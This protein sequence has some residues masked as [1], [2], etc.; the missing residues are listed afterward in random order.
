[1]SRALDDS[2]EL[3]S[4]LTDP[5]LPFER[6]RAI[7]DDLIGGRASSLSVAIV[8]L[9]VSQGRASDLPEIVE[10]F[11]E[12]AAAMR[13]HA[14][15][16]VRTAVP[17]DDETIDRLAKALSRA[18]G[19][20]VEVKVEIDPDVIGGVVARV[21]DTVIDGSIARRV[22]SLRQAIKTR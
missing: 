19:K 8:Q 17:L 4:T 2:A 21:G 10:A 5:Q 18:T 12:A 16:E 6:K 22:E 15:A 13:D 14:V 11:V 3:R 20:A 1:V 7:V 9:I